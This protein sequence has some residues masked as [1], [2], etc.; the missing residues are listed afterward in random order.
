MQRISPTHR[1]RSSRYS[2]MASTAMSMRT[3]SLTFGAYLPAL[4]AERWITVWAFAPIASFFSIGCGRAWNEVTTRKWPWIERLAPMATAALA[5]V[6][7]FQPSGTLA[8][9][10]ALLA[11]FANAVRLWGWQPW[12]AGQ[13]PM[14][15]VLHL[16]YG[17]LALGLGL[18]AAAAWLPT[19]VMPAVHA[20]TVGAL[21]G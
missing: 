7:L 21:G 6:A 12:R 8:A 9:L 15:W 10:L 19:L 18:T 14:L 16:G 17:W 11:C 5:L 4:N 3:S 20:L 1:D 2:L 13:K